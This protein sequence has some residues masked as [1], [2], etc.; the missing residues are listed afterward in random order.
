MIRDYDSNWTTRMVRAE[1]CI[2]SA[3]HDYR[4]W[5]VRGAAQGE[6]V[7]LA[8][9]GGPGG[10]FVMLNP[11]RARAE[12]RDPT[13]RRCQAFARKFNWAW[14]G[15]VNLFATSS[16][17]PRSVFDFGYD[18][19]IGPDNDRIIAAVFHEALDH[20]WPVVC[21]WGAPSAFNKTQTQL[22]RQ[23]ALEVM[24]SYNARRAAGVRPLGV[25]DP[26]HV[27]PPRLCCLE[28]TA[29]GWPRH[30][31]YLGIAQ[32]NLTHHRPAVYQPY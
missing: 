9:G 16:S 15:I 7:R 26:G 20:R 12:I 10:I 19:A 25:L 21:A 1:S 30:P 22:V 5:L 32:G 11:S 13:D 6:P 31:L 14:Y 3:N 2:E 23:R 28:H 4:Y 29:D 27:D 24:T 18:S 17:N 8:E